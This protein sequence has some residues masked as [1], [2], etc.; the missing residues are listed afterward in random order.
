MKKI[1]LILLILITGCSSTTVQPKPSETTVTTTPK[2]RFELTEKQNEEIDKLINNSEYLDSFISTN[3]KITYTISENLYSINLD[4][5]YIYK[6]RIQPNEN[7]IFSFTP[8]PYVIKYNKDGK[9]KSASLFLNFNS[10]SYANSVIDGSLITNDNQNFDL[11]FDIKNLQ[12]NDTKTKT[13]IEFLDDLYNKTLDSAK[14]LLNEYLLE[15]SKLK[16][17]GILI[18]QIINNDPNYQHPS[19]AILLVDDRIQEWMDSDNERQKPLKTDYITKVGT[20]KVNDGE[21]KNTKDLPPAVKISLLFFFI[22]DENPSSEQLLAGLLSIFPEYQCVNRRCA[23]INNQKD[24]LFINQGIKGEG[25]YVVLTQSRVNHLLATLLN[26]EPISI[27]E[28][29]KLS[30]GIVQSN[31]EET[32]VG[33][34]LSGAFSTNAY[35]LIY[36]EISSSPDEIIVQV[37]PYTLVSNKLADKDFIVISDTIYSQEEMYNAASDNLH[38]LT[39]WEVALKP[40]LDS[41]YYQIVYYYK[42]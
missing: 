34:V 41:N 39:T 23:N 28:T 3:T 19:Q 12:I 42:I 14:I 7:V 5:T 18:N 38:L 15:Q 6:I 9:E 25:Y 35:G 29:K 40:A 24:E 20:I 13:K 27:L 21:L 31:D 1:I 16:S 22:E 8:D 11:Q 37:T 2:T 10:N 33:E 26:R 4:G 32:F 30:N 36:K 17:L